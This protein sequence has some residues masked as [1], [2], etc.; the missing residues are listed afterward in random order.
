MH[1]N[2]RVNLQKRGLD[3]AS[4][5]MLFRKMYYFGFSIWSN[6]ALRIYIY[7][8][9]LCFHSK[10]PTRKLRISRYNSEYG[11]FWVFGVKMT[12]FYYIVALS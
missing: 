4:K 12:K 5:V 8:Y 6:F 2:Q 7:L 10:I 3:F 1:K 11:K 9:V